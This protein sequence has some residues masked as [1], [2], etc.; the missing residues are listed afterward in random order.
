MAVLNPLCEVLCFF[1]H[2]Q[3]VA[4]G[5]TAVSR[6]ET[7][8]AEWKEVA[9]MS[10][11]KTRME[12]ECCDVASQRRRRRYLE[13]LLLV[14]SSSGVVRASLSGKE[15]G[16]RVNVSEVDLSSLAIFRTIPND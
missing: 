3:R 2:C 13:T 14:S 5:V 4:F 9:T 12:C 6:Y 8:A 10:S 15:R 11:W 7:R 16:R 1:S